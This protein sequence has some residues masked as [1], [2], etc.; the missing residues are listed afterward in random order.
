MSQVFKIPSTISAH[1][2]SKPEMVHMS[3]LLSFIE[4]SHEI[5]GP[6]I[7]FLRFVSVFK[8]KTKQNK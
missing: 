8:G 1:T 3:S 7:G 2:L 5:E 6:G 4:H